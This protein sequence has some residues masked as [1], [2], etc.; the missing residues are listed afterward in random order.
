MP[1]KELEIH[2]GSER[3]V[4]EQEPHADGR[5]LEL[6]EE[7]TTA[8]MMEALRLESYHWPK[9]VFPPLKKSGHIILDSCTPEG[10]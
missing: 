8:D 5:Y 1:P 3:L 6:M 10:E 7:H 9:L 4:I 2:D